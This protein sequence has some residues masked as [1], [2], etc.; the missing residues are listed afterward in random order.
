MSGCINKR[1]CPIPPRV[2]DTLRQNELMSL[3]GVIAPGGQVGENEPNELLRQGCSAWPV[4]VK[5]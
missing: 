3:M 1:R 2:D 5:F 4:K